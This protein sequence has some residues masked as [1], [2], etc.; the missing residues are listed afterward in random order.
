LLCRP[1]PTQKEWASFGRYKS[2]FRRAAPL[3]RV[4]ARPPTRRAIPTAANAGRV[5]VNG[6]Y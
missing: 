3:A 5:V 4:L 6:W 2:L 1:K